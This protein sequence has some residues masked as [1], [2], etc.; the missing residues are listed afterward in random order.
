MGFHHVLNDMFHLYPLFY[1]SI[2]P[3]Q[4]FI[5]IGHVVPAFFSFT[6]IPILQLFSCFNRFMPI[7]RAKFIFSAAF[8]ALIRLSSSRN[9]TSSTQCRLFSIPQCALALPPY[10]AAVAGANTGEPLPF[11]MSFPE[12]FHIIF[13]VIFPFFY[14]P[15]LPAEV[16]IVTPRFFQAAF[17]S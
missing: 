11:R 10:S 8:P 6:G 17:F 4:Y 9:A 15:M 12:P 5:K 14:P 13:N 3:G 1:S 2:Q 7:W 16:L